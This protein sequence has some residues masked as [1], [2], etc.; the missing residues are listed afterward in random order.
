MS[1]IDINIIDKILI[2]TINRVKKLNALNSQVI[3][4]LDETFSSY[5]D[6]LHELPFTI[7]GSC[8]CLIQPILLHP[9]AL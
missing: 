9:F 5:L 4:E 6:N 3:K 7:F 1:Y 8:T 2:I